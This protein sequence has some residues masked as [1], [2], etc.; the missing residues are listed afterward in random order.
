V[1]LEK[2][3]FDSAAQVENLSM[4]MILK[5]MGEVGEG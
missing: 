3:E 1:K 2:D 4:Q 5:S